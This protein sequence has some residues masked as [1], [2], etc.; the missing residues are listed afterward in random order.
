MADK[1]R[2][3]RKVTWHTSVQPVHTLKCLW[4]HRINGTAEH[5]CI[6]IPGRAC[7]E[8]FVDLL[9]ASCTQA[10]GG[11]GGGFQGELEPPDPP[12]Q[13]LAP[14]LPPRPPPAPGEWVE[15]LLRST[16][17]T[18]PGLRMGGGSAGS[19]LRSRGPLLP[20]APGSEPLHPAPSSRGAGARGVTWGDSRTHARF[21]RRDG[22]PLEWW[23]VPCAYRRARLARR[24]R[25]VLQRRGEGLMPAGAVWLGPLEWPEPV[26]RLE[27]QRSA[28]VLARRSR[29]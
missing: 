26:P 28:G 6:C 23:A 29:R 25:W 10:C 9:A 7:V 22:G 19:A 27:R 21:S 5:C 11:G 13:P 2:P 17:V 20:S 3:E 4:N 8:R 24:W 1:T 15:P 12:W 14:V 18:A 16:P